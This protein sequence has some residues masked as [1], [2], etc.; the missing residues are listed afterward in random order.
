MK[1]ELLSSII[2]SKWGGMDN[3]HPEPKSNRSRVA[4]LLVALSLF[5]AILVA[6]STPTSAQQDNSGSSGNC[7]TEAKP[8]LCITA[9]S[10]ASTPGHSQRYG[11]GERIKI[12]ATFSTDVT[13]SEDDPQPGLAFQ[14]QNWSADT[15]TALYSRTATYDSQPETNKLIFVY[16]VRPEDRGKGGS[17]VPNSSNSSPQL[18]DAA[19][20]KSTTLGTPTGTEYATASQSFA[21]IPIDIDHGINGELA[22]TAFKPTLTSTAVNSSRPINRL[23]PKYQV[24]LYGETIEISMK[25]TAPLDVTGVPSVILDGFDGLNNE[26]IRH[27]NYVRGTGTD[28]LVFAYTVGPRDRALLGIRMRPPVSGSRMSRV[29]LPSASQTDSHSSS[30]AASG[31]RERNLR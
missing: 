10:F 5:A 31:W 22:P 6:V 12:E 15:G 17:G 1:M 20:I 4:R 7:G 13:V 8:E 28:T 23:Q 18:T 19:S 25:F 21:G 14:F 9:L 16:I 2:K 27:A 11:V 24:Y 26:A 3:S 29:Q 30:P